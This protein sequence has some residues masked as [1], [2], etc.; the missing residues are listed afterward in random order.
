MQGKASQIKFIIF[1]ISQNAKFRD[2]TYFLSLYIWENQY[3]KA[4]FYMSNL[5][6]ILHERKE[7]KKEN[8]I[9]KETDLKKKKKKITEDLSMYSSAVM[10][11]YPVLSYVLLPRCLNSN[12]LEFGRQIA[13]S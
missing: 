13:V 5:P 6:D 1:M 7:K 2:L 12:S 10:S 8:V 3:Q 11:P 9:W 4:F